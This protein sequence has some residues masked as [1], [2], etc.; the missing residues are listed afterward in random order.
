M[1][2]Y[3]CINQNAGVFSCIIHNEL[4][5]LSTQRHFIISG[6]LSCN[7]VRQDHIL[8]IKIYHLLTVTFFCLCSFETLNNLKTLKSHSFCVSEYT[9]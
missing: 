7:D 4:T 3:R 1:F 9:R 8:K 2:P 5:N 6:S